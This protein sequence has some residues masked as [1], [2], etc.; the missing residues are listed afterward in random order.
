METSISG[1][2]CGGKT[3]SHCYCMIWSLARG[4]NNRE[5][6]ESGARK[7]MKAARLSCPPESWPA[8]K[9]AI[10]SDEIS[11]VVQPTAVLPPPILESRTKQ[12]GSSSLQQVSRSLSPDGSMSVSPALA[13]ALARESCSS[14]LTQDGQHLH[15]QRSRLWSTRL[16]TGSGFKVTGSLANQWKE[17]GEFSWLPPTVGGGRRQA[18]MLKIDANILKLSERP[19]DRLCK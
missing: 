9:P 5:S 10:K 6:W 14:F 18:G 2:Y 19:V 16:T 12:A 8:P 4:L 1:F 3:A 17:P 15:G 7:L 13:F 11:L